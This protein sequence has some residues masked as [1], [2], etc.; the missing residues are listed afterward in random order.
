MAT[1]SEIEE[2]LKALDLRKLLTESIEETADQ[3]VELNQQQ[4]YAGK[5]GDGREISPQYAR[6]D[7]AVMKNQMN[8]A[9]GYGTPDL[10]LTGAF[11]QGYGVRVEGDEV[12]KDSNVEYADQLFEKY[13]NAIGELDEGRHEEYVEGEMGPVFYDKVREQTGLI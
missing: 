9:P 7:Y 6:Q 3:Y 1:A 2:R 11:Y 5:D 8:P 10:K 12:I 4:M 13:G